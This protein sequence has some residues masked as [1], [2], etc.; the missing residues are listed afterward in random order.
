MQE[1]LRVWWPAQQHPP[2]QPSSSSSP[3]L[4]S[5]FRVGFA[6]LHQRLKHPPNF[7]GQKIKGE[8]VPAVAEERDERGRLVIEVVV[9]WV[10]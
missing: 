7:A 4:A 3:S 1:L 10:F 5:S 2:Q 9:F 8:E 6:I